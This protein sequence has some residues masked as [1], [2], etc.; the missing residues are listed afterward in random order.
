NISD[1]SDIILHHRAGA[2][3]NALTQSEYQQALIEIDTILKR[4]EPETKNR[5]RNL[6][7]TYRN[8]QI[9]HQVYSTIYSL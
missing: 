8:F 2:V 5:I 6:A 7:V 4:P 1:D 3:L 9:A